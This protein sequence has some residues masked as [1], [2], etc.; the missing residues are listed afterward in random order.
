MR[1]SAEFI[2]GVGALVAALS[3]SGCGQGNS[4]DVAG[5]GTAP[6]TGPDS[7]LLFPNPLVRADGTFEM[8]STAYAQAYYTAIDPNNDK[9]TLEK[10]KASNGFGS[11]TGAQ[12]G[13][14]FGDMRDLGYG[15]RMTARQNSN[16]T[17]AFLVENYL[18]N[19]GPD[20]GNAAL[21][22][23]SRGAAGPPLDCFVQRS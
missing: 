6:S 23:R 12:V 2:V 5:S 18:I 8:N 7:F 10:W 17:I 14:V 16:G 1:C 19:I 21:N 13:V 3:I 4:G 22:L 15:R 11:G 9:D 20:Y